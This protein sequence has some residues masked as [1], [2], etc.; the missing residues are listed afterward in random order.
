MCWALFSF[1]QKTWEWRG[2]WDSLLGGTKEKDWKPF[3][4]IIKFQLLIT[5][6]GYLLG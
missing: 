3:H 4:L 6:C 1:F 5:L 2:W